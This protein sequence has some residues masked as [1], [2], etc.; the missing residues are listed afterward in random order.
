[1]DFENGLLEIHPGDMGWRIEQQAQNAWGLDSLEPISGHFSLHHSLDNDRAAC[2]YYIMHH[3]P[4]RRSQAQD[5]VFSGDSLSFTFRLRH[6]YPPSSGNNWQVAILAEHDGNIR[7]GIVIGV[8][9]VGSDDLVKVWRARN[10]KYEDLCAS[11][12]DFQQEVGT[13]DSPFFRLSWQWDGVLR[14]FFASNSLSDMYE[15]ASCFLDELPDGRS[16]VIRYEYSSAQDRKLW[17]DDLHLEGR[18]EP[19]TIPPLITAWSLES[20]NILNLNFSRD[21]IWSDST[22]VVL[23]L[24]PQTGKPSTEFT[25]LPDSFSVKESFLRLF[26]PEALPNREQVALKMQGVCN[27][28]GYAMA[29]TLLQLMRNEAV[30]GD[31]VINEVMADPDPALSLSLG[32]YVELYNRSEYQLKLEGWVLSLGSR[33]YELNGW[34]EVAPIKPGEYRVIYP[35]LLSNQGSTLALFSK[36]GTLVHAASYRIP[37]NAARWKVEGGWSLESPDPDRVCNLSKLWEYSMDR[38]GGTPGEEN[39]VRSERPDRQEPCFLYFGYEPEGLLA[40][41]FSEVV[42]LAADL[43]N[44]VVLNPGN[45]HASEL[46]VSQ[47]IGDR[48][49]CRFL[50]DPS[51]L[52]RYSF[53]MPAVSDCSGNY[54]QELHFTGGRPMAPV[55]G[56]VLINEI[57]FK[58]REGAA[59]YIELYNPGQHFVDIRDLGLDV[60]GVEEGQDELRP[61]SDHSRIMGPGEYLVLTG[62]V[63]HLMDSYGLDISGRWLELENFESLPDGGGRIWLCDRTSNGIDVV[64]YHDDMHMDLIA[65]TRG[66]ALERINSEGLGEDPHNWHSAASIENYATPGRLNSQ[67]LT[68]SDSDNRLMLDPRV[69]SPNNDGFNDFL[70]ISPGIEDPGWVIRLWITRPD[71][72]PVRMLANNHV[73]GTSSQYTWDGREDSGKMAVGGFYVVHL[74]AYNPS[75]GSSWNHKRAVGLVY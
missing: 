11:A 25:V 2:D 36:E 26:F 21:I 63:D 16:L 66:I 47:P 56:S 42:H 52:T 19:D 9:L 27:R 60:T 74:R 30:W 69:I 13:G 43:A 4:F 15:I 53:R 68:G 20:S 70:I 1:V 34:E 75:S 18:F 72:M 54:S 37:Y 51:I 49:S 65:D 40:L 3:H 41:H 5:Q 46:M 67:S 62:Q 45:Y 44:E 38:K 28:D 71:G 58:P 61:L 6:A 33:K 14:L 12:L 50:L 7:D 39:S 22:K 10:G 55:K 35:G 24:A 57:M 17:I 73:A 48:L 64:S 29:D 59:E 31:L 23:L 32:E 8:N